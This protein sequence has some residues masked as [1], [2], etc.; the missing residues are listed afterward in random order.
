MMPSFFNKPAETKWVKAI[1]V[2]A[3][4]FSV[5]EDSWP[6]EFRVLPKEGDFVESDQG[7]RLKII[8]VTH[9]KG[10]YDPVVELELGRDITSVTP[11]EGGTPAIGMEPE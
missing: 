7:R 2:I 6:T 9:K 1:C 4:M 3:D 5:G 10:D 11:T 8:R